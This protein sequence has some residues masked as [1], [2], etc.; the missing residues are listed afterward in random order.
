MLEMEKLVREEQLNDLRRELAREELA[1]EAMASRT[2][3]APFYLRVLVW[4]VQR[5]LLW[6]VHLPMS[7]PRP[8][9]RTRRYSSRASC[10]S[11]EGTLS[12]ARPSRQG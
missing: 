7:A 10:P 8:R 3:S 12:V 9:V 2:K 11:C 4:L 6:C 1:R 5:L